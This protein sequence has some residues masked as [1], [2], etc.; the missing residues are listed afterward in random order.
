MLRELEL[1]LASD[2]RYATRNTLIVDAFC[3]ALT[4]HL[5]SDFAALREMRAADNRYPGIR[6]Q[7]R[8]LWYVGKELAA[9]E[10]GPE[11]LVPSVIG[12]QIA[13]Y[14]QF[15]Q[16]W[17]EV[18]DGVFGLGQ[19]HKPSPTDELLNDMLDAARRQQQTSD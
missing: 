4:D 19:A 16:G 5:A 12:G 7:H 3:R 9:L 15:R 2:P 18:L 11:V 10:G 6:K 8:Y 14:G 1:Y 13:F 17:L